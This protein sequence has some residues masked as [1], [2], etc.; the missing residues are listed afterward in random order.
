M[1]NFLLNYN[2]I[3]SKRNHNIENTQNNTGKNILILFG[4]NW[5]IVLGT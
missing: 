2:I 4:K 5:I 1:S 3:R